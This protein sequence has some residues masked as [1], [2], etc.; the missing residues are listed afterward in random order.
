[1]DIIKYFLKSIPNIHTYGRM[2]P[3]SKNIKVILLKS[4]YCDIGGE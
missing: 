3:I 1:M 4:Y 2:L